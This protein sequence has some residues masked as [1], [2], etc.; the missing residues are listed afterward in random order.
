MSDQ[1]PAVQRFL[2]HELIH[3]Y[4]DAINHN[5]W[6]AYRDCWTDDGVF[7][8]V[9]SLVDTAGDLENPLG[10]R[11]ANLRV[12]GRDAITALVTRYGEFD[13]AFQIPTAIVAAPEGPDDARLRHVLQIRTSG[14]TT[15]GF[16]YDRAVRDEDGVWRL[17][18]RE[19]RPSYFE[20]PTYSGVVTRTLPDPQ[21]RERPVPLRLPAEG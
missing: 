12:E 3:R 6:S 5:D 20:R 16:C 1:D 18:H 2:L 17:A 11:P 7:E 15:V 14:M 9:D 19:Y 8:Q 21:Y 10:E 13:W 4:A